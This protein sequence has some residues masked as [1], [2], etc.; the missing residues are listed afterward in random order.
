[1]DAD[2]W[3][4]INRLLDEAFELEPDKRNA[5]LE[6]ACGGD[7][8]L[9][10]EVEKLLHSDE[11]AQSFI[12]IPAVQ[13]VAESLSKD[14][15]SSG[16]SLGPYKIVSEIGTGGMGEVYRAQDPRLDRIVA[17]KIL[18]A[19]LAQDQDRMRRFHQEAKAASKL[20]HPNVAHIY[21][22]GS[23]ANIRFIA[24]EYVEG[25]TLDERISKGLLEV[26][27]MID[28]GMQVADALDEAHQKGITHRDIKPAN[29]MIKDKGHVKVLDFGLAKILQLPQDVPPTQFSTIEKTEAGLVFG[30]VPYMSPEQ[31]LG[32]EV[33]HRSDIFSLGTV[34]YQM[35][36]SKLPF[37]GIGTVEV[38]DHVLHVDPDPISSFNPDAPPEL[39][40]IIRKCLEKD[41]DRRYQS[42]RDLYVDLKNLRRDS[43]SG[44]VIKQANVP[45]RP[46][47]RFRTPAI[48]MLLL[49]IAIAGT[50]L[51]SRMRSHQTIHSIAVLP[52]LNS[53]GNQETEY[54]S[55]GITESTIKAL[56]LLPEMR[57]M[58]PGTVFTYKGK[59][60][61]PR[62]VGRDL[63]VDA[64]LS[65]SVRQTGDLLMIE[66]SLADV[67]DGSLLWG[68]QFRRPL[69][70]ITNLASEIS[71]ELSGKLQL[72]LAGKA[73]KLA[74]KQYTN[75]SDAYRLYLKGRYFLNKRTP[76]G[77]KKAIEF[78][79]QAI[80]SDP[81]YALAYAGLSELYALG[82]DLLKS[83]A[84]AMK[85]LELDDNLAEAHVSLAAIK[86]MEWDW[87]GEEN[88]FKKAI[89]LNPNLA[90]AHMQYGDS[91][92]IRGELDQAIQ[93]TRLAQ[94][95][96]PLNVHIA[97][98]L[99]N[100]LNMARRGD[101]ALTEI[102][103]AID[104]D[105]NFP[106]AHSILAGIYLGKGIYAESIQEEAKAMTL[107]GRKPEIIAQYIQ[108]LMDGLRE[109]GAKGYWEKRLEFAKKRA[110]ELHR[111]DDPI[112]LA[113]IHA[114]LGQKDEAFRWLE[115]AYQDRSYDL[116]VYI[117]SD[118]MWDPIRSD[119]RYTELL[120]K[121]RLL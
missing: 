42:C 9:K 55:D 69:S 33:D 58:A 57:V 77:F 39:E 105:P 76:Q 85:A 95:L 13:A 22:M 115:K 46:V 114:Q 43:E 79:R 100:K 7:A 111:Q 19:H 118:P 97:T 3:K 74:N 88:E 78:F 2:R 29:I 21:E 10:Q 48:I 61:D 63:K 25:Q 94:Q 60:V 45:V 99:S 49:L 4:E 62:K 35:A 38:L 86:S 104:M 75:D 121:C 107:R 56:S 80:D 41:R 64:V 54:L 119:L 26:P 59:N 14:K 71:R 1:M 40:R 23:S 68:S 106:M 5:Y 18:P 44:V 67:S 113:L 81:N 91:L 92:A 11:R 82:D 109:E 52:F 30:T 101:E 53:G 47:T 32:W 84:A 73:E 117:K 116:I 90:N 20:S 37:T 108:L 112:E 65:G 6:K 12:E 93:E 17:L 120:K 36:T 31:A 24:M 27:E 66:A 83:K 50:V 51:L 102:R 8:A 34:L 16:Q 103:K 72:K 28:I 89:Q 87:S 96:D 110:A 98:A 15:L 70:D